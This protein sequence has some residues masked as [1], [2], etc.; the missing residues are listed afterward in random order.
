[1][2]RRGLSLIE[3]IVAAGLFALAVP[4]LLNLLPTSFLSLRRSETI[5]T[6]TSLA[7]Y[8]LDEVP[9]LPPREGV[10]LDESIAV[11]DR[12][13]RLVREFYRVDRVRWD[14]VIVCTTEELPPCRLATRVLRDSD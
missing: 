10:D 11:K 4:L 5:Q 12:V 9:F 13:Y 14:V 7:L 1:M 2:R 3:V 6:A 8:R